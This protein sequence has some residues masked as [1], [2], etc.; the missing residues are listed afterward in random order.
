MKK[1]LTM[2][3]SLCL[4]L[5]MATG[6]SSTTDDTPAD[7]TNETGEIDQTTFEELLEAGKEN[8]K[9]VTVYSTHS[10]VVSACE[11]FKNKFDLDVEFECT[12][13]GDTDQITQVATEV[14]TGAAG[15]DI[16]FIQDGARVLTDLVDEGY[17]VNWYN[18]EIYDAVGEEQAEP[19]LVWDYCNKV[20]IYNTDNVAE[21]EINNIW[22]VTDEKY[23]GTVMMKDPFTEG[24][25]MDFLT[26]ITSDENA[27]LLEEAYKEYYGEDLVLDDDCPNAGYQWIK[28][29]YNNGLVVG[30]SDGDMAQSIGAEGQT[31][32]WS[33]LITLNKYVKNLEIGYKLGYTSDV[34]PFAGF[35]YP[36]YGLLTSN[37]DNPEMAK[38]FLCWLYTEDGWFGDGETTLNDGSVYVG[39]TGR[40]G[41]YSANTSL[42]VA[43]G[44]QE[45]SVWKDI[46]IVEDP[47]YA[48]E[49]RADVEDFINLIK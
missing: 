32:P 30:T 39:M 45:L 18:Q 44:D 42:A 23:A 28:M 14:S 15:A 6:C 17:V 8:G 46:L 4:C 13:I 21:D 38:A 34:T 5:G 49:H 16:I 27:A 11:A 12:Q 2:F 1:F 47:E 31:K 25:N 29:L 40:Q 43:D 20:F 7:D 35:I 24:V 37:A 19:L 26:V 22:Y 10:V 9:K 36:I 3:C 41:D 33:G 48:A